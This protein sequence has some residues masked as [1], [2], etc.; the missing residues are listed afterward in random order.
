LFYGPPVS[1]NIIFSLRDD[2]QREVRLKAIEDDREKS[3]STS[4]E[5]KE[6]SVSPTLVTSKDSDYWPIW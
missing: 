1:T 3:I 4:R 5:F 2:D 6:S